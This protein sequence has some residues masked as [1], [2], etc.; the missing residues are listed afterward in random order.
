MDLI[1][2]SPFKLL[3]ILC[4]YTARFVSDLTRNPKDWFSHDTAHIVPAAGKMTACK[5]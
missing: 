2:P 3:A 1:D 4:G 5:F